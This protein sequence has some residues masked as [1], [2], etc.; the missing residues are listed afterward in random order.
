MEP[1]IFLPLTPSLGVWLSAEPDTLLGAFAAAKD[2]ES[3]QKRSANLLILSPLPAG[4]DP[5][6]QTIPISTDWKDSRCWPPLFEYITHSRG[7][8]AALGLY[9]VLWD[10][11]HR[12]ST[13]YAVASAFVAAEAPLAEAFDFPSIIAALQPLAAVMKYRLPKF[14]TM[15][16]GVALLDRLCLA[17][18]YLASK[19]V[20]TNADTKTSSE[21]S[22]EYSSF[23]MKLPQSG[24]VPGAMPPSPQRPERLQMAPVWRYLQKTRPLFLVS[25]HPLA[26]NVLM[27]PAPGRSSSQTVTQDVADLLCTYGDISC[28]LCLIDQYEMRKL[29]LNDLSRQIEACN[30]PFK[31]FPIVEMSVP[32]SLPATSTLVGELLTAAA[33]GPVIV[34]CRGGLGRAGLIT[35]CLWLQLTM[36]E[37]GGALGSASAES[38]AEEAIA[39]VR[40]LRKGAIETRGQEQ[41]IASFAAFLEGDQ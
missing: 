37:E 11:M 9:T 8:K 17:S 31:S 12:P 21:Q 5:S 32:T 6:C 16:I 41:F 19:K 35:A 40:C 30:I 7:D 39:A 10:P 28:W 15:P 34:H 29:Q 2:N 20:R 26:A 38:R 3:T 22:Q 23:R 14:D 1:G 27:A 13:I 18:N 36:G 33:K 4:D 24:N 25:S